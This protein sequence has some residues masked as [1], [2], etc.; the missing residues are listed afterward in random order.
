MFLHVCVQN[1]SNFVLKIWKIDV[2]R[3]SSTNL[4][5]KFK[6]NLKN[7]P[8]NYCNVSLDSEKVTWNKNDVKIEKILILKKRILGIHKSDKPQWLI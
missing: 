4:K 6:C 3:C 8:T 2:L 1:T 7:V 5:D